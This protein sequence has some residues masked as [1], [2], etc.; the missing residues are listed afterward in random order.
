MMLCQYIITCLAIL[1]VTFGSIGNFET[2]VLFE[3]ISST[4]PALLDCS[5][6]GSANLEWQY[7]NPKNELSTLSAT[8]PLLQLD[9]LNSV[10]E[11]FCKINGNY[12]KNFTV[13]YLSTP[14]IQV[15]LLIHFL[16]CG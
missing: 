5:G 2:I 14:L 9:S 11:Y 13:A 12:V 7:S 10:G 4:N 15:R 8:G 6:S 3:N 16:T 1:L